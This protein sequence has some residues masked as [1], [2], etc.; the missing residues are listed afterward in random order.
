MHIRVI[1]IGVNRF[2]LLLQKGKIL[3]DKGRIFPGFAVGVFN[4]NLIYT[5]A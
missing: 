3:I 5:L 1:K 2:A 4:R